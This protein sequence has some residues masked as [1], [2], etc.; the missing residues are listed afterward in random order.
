MSIEISFLYFN[1]MVIDSLKAKAIGKKTDKVT[2]PVSYRETV[3]KF[4]IKGIGS[5]RDTMTYVE[6]FKSA[7]STGLKQTGLP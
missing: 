3:L 2:F 4:G 7:T 6:I 1:F 5:L